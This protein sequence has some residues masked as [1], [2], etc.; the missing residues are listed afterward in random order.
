M[1]HSL[2]WGMVCLTLI[3]KEA[4]AEKNHGALL[5]FQCHLRF[6]PENSTW[7]I[8]SKLCPYLIYRVI[9][10]TL[11]NLGNQIGQPHLMDEGTEKLVHRES[12]WPRINQ[13]ANGR[14]RN[15]SQRHP[16]SMRIC[17]K[18]YTVCKT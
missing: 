18:T 12:N 13:A 9:N 1:C 15:R 10:R 7:L 2:S 17:G 8:H 4:D 3:T 6:P 14:V 16:V 5:L 11:N